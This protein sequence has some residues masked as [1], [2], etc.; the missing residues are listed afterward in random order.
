MLFDSN[1]EM[2][3]DAK[4]PAGYSLACRSVE[5]QRARLEFDD[6][7]GDVKYDSFNHEPVVL[8]G[9]EM[10]IP[11]VGAKWRVTSLPITQ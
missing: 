2:E 4:Q 3:N 6:D 7:G 5:R 10:P 9:V 1:N 8:F 11:K